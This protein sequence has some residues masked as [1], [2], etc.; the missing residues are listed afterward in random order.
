MELV[1]QEVGASCAPVSIVYSKEAAPRPLIDLLELRL[2]NIEN[3]ADSILIIIPDNSLMRIGGIA[4]HHAIL[5]TCELRGV[6]AI[7]IPLDLLLLHLYVLLLLLNGHD[8]PSICNQLILTF[9]LIH[10][11]FFH[12]FGSSCRRL[13]FAISLR[14][15]LSWWLGSLRR[16]HSIILCITILRNKFFLLVEQDRLGRLFS[17]SKVVLR[18]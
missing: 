14:F 16:R 2:D 10:R 4:A 11:F 6:V 3:D 7:D 12:F 9:A 1:P 8:E 15:F 13:A 17:S 5:L 18:F